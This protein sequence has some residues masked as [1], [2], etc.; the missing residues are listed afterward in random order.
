MPTPRS[1][2]E[3]RQ[4]EAQSPESE[5]KPKQESEIKPADF[6]VEDELQQEAGRDSKPQTEDGFLDEA[7]SRLRT[8]LRSGKKKPTLVQPHL[9]DEITLKVEHIMEEGLADAFRTLTPL[10]QQEFKLK[11]EK[12]AW[13]I[14]DL[15]RETKVKIKKIF[16]LLVEWLK[17]LPGIN[18]FFLE[19][20]AKIKADRI[21]ALHKQNKEYK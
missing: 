12:T 1:G 20:E 3:L 13:E 16:R 9:R 7:I 18:R 15:L 21:M 17:I 19:Q 6:L 8:A 2:S 14:R 11:G 10:Q 5:Q 4:Q